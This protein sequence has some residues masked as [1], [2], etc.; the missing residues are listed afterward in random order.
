MGMRGAV[1]GRHDTAA[2]CW[3]EEARLRGAGAAAGCGEATPDG[4]GAMAGGGRRR[5]AGRWRYRDKGRGESRELT[6]PSR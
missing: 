1:A 6:W 5:G 4:G 3:S 2:A